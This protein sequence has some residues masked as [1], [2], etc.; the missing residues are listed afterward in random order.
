MLP[1]MYRYTWYSTA[2]VVVQYHQVKR[3]VIL[4]EASYEYEPS[5]TRIYTAV[6]IRTRDGPENH[7][8][9]DCVRAG[10]SV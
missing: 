10:L 2:V 9:P 4:S 7:V 3:V 8:F 6:V 1:G 5:S